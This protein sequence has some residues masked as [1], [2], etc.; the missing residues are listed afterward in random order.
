MTKVKEVK[1]MITAGEAY[2]VYN[3]RALKIG[4]VNEQKHNVIVQAVR[5]CAAEERI[6]QR[7]MRTMR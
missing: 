1:G 2:F 7:R 3:G 5:R 4:E 6:K